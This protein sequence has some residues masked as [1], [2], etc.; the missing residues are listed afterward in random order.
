MKKLLITGATLIALAGAVFAQGRFGLDSGTD[1]YGVAINAAGNYYTGNVGVEIWELNGT[2]STAMMNAINQAD[3]NPAGGG[4][5]AYALMLADG[6]TKE[7]T[8]G[9]AGVSGGIIYVA[10]TQLMPD[11][12]PPAGLVTV[13]LAMWNNSQGS[14]ANMVAAATASTRAGVTAFSQQ[15]GLPPGGVLPIQTWN[16]YDLVMTTVPEPSTFALAG[17]GAAALV[18]FRRRK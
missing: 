6:F 2:P 9:S 5:T 8:L 14:W 17:L 3:Q 4:V 15:T 10:G 11:V 18:I 16:S 7:V 13:A 1:L 12:N